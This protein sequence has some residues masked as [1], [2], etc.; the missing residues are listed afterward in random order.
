VPRETDW[1]DRMRGVAD[2]AQEKRIRD[3][4]AAQLEAQRDR[5]QHDPDMLKRNGVC[6]VCGRNIV[7]E[8]AAALGRRRSPAK[9]AAARLNGARGGRPLGALPCIRCEALTTDR[10]ASRRACCTIHST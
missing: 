1:R 8:A 9:S 4:E 6:G 7:S 2:P 3:V 5:C 10:D